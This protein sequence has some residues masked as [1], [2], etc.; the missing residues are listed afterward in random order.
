MTIAQIKEQLSITALDLSRGE[1]QGK[2][3]EF[4]SYWDDK[5]RLRVVIHEDVM[6]LIKEDRDIN[7]LALKYQRKTAEFNADEQKML[8]NI[9]KDSDREEMADQLALKKQYDYYDLINAKSI[10]ESF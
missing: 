3:S 1:Y 5:R 8:K 2:P 9:K 10:E 7:S 4:L 6:K